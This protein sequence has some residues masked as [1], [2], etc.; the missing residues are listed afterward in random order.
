MKIILFILLYMN[1]DT[2]EKN[3][4][5]PIEQISLD[6]KNISRDID[7]IRTDLQYIKILIRAKEETRDL[8]K[9]ET[10]KSGWFFS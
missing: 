9:Q 2:E 3:K 10:I 1:S 6:I 5:K 8:E 7:S 4:L